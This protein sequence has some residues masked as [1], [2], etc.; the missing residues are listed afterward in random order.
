[1]IDISRDPYAVDGKHKCPHCKGD[2]LFGEWKT[3]IPDEGQP[4]LF[5]EEDDCSFELI[6]GEENNA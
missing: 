6:F 5:C 4:G 1:M 3:D 2:L